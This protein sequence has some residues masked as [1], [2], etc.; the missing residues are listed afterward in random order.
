VTWVLLLAV[1]FVLGIIWQI[2]FVVAMTVGFVLDR[3]WQIRF[4]REQQYILRYLSKYAG[5]SQYIRETPP[6]ICRQ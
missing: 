3:I 1:G 5:G 2:R 4:D 6:A